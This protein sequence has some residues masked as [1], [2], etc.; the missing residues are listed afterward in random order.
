MRGLPERLFSPPVKA[1][2]WNI[3]F[4]LR[5]VPAAIYSWKSSCMLR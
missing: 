1:A 5:A 2:Y 3:V 4:C